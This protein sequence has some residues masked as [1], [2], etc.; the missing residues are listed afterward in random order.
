MAR[1]F[2]GS[3]VVAL[4]VLLTRFL[5]TKGPAE[6][7]GGEL[8]TPGPRRLADLPQPGELGTAAGLLDDSIHAT[9]PVIPSYLSR[10][11]RET[12]SASSSACFIFIMPFLSGS[13]LLS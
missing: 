3:V 13:L 12:V 7:A 10:A 2:W 1:R 5:R 9:H 6:L 8:G 11:P 4:L